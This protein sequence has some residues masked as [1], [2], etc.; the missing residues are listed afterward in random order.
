LLAPLAAF[1]SGTNLLQKLQLLAQILLTTARIPPTRLS[2]HRLAII[3]LEPLGQGL[4]RSVDVVLDAVGVRARVI[5]VQVLV[6]V[7]DEVGRCA[8]GV[9]DVVERGGTA[10]RDE[11]LGARE[12]LAGH[13][14]DVGFSGSAADCGD[15]GLDCVGPLA[16]VGDVLAC[17]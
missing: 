17:C 2:Q 4:E 10:G 5:G 7:H 8:V 11:R 16:D 9:L 3:L 6:H 1:S 14:D 15:D 13:Q 12:A